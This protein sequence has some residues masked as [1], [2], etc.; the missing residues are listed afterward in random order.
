[1]KESFIR[2]RKKCDALTAGNESVFSVNEI[3]FE[4]NSGIKVS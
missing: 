1:M 3:S 4:Y 2:R